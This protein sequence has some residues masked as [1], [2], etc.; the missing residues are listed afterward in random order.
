L[1]IVAIAPMDEPMERRW[2]GNLLGYQATWLI[3]VIAAGRGLWWPGVL[4]A[5]AFAAS[6]LALARDRRRMLLVLAAALPIGA[7]VDGSLAH[8]GLL[9]YAAPSPALPAGGAPLWILGL[10]LAFAATL[11]CSLAFLQRRRWVAAAFG[12]VGAPLA[13]LGAAHG[14]QAV[15]FAAPSWQALLVLAGAWTLALPVLA[16]IARPAP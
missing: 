4:A 11:P 10:W 1:R 12:A 2:W 14:W 3:A 7:I 15:V 8:G 13:Y 16:T 6:Q 5:L 9:R